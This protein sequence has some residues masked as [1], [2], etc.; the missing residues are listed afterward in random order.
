MAP[1]TDAKAPQSTKMHPKAVITGS[2]P[3]GH[4]AGHTTA[5][6]LAR[7]NLNP[8][9]VE[10]FITNGFVAGSYLNTAT[11]EFMGKF[12]E[13]SLH[14]GI[15]TITETDDGEAET[16]DTIII[17]TG[18]SVRR[19]GL[20]GKV[21][22]ASGISAC[23]ACT[24]RQRKGEF[25]ASKSLQNNP[26]I[27][28]LWNA[29]TTDSYQGDWKKRTCHEP[30]TSLVQADPDGYI[31]TVPGRTTLA[32]GYRQAVTSAGSGCMAALVVG[33]LIAEEEEP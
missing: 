22:S 29:I 27:T 16:A 19:L 13:Q 14:S 2:G 20:K 24:E 18:A 28:I 9:F 21:T 32:S 15:I 12:R 25:C 7:A 3:A 26:K 4:T 17:T 10:R 6:Y 11:Y 31:M 5:I 33:R 30:A 23:A 1:I 8:V